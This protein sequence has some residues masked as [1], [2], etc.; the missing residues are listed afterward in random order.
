MPVAEKCEE[1][2]EE[3]FVGDRLCAFVLPY[4]GAYQN[5]SLVVQIDSCD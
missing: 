3:E 2:A 4:S 1:S 5:V